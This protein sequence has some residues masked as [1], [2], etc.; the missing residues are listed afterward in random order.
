LVF[1]AVTIFPLHSPTALA[2]AVPKYLQSM[3]AKHSWTFK[4][5]ILIDDLKR[6]REQLWSEAVVR[7]R[8]SLAT[9]APPSSWM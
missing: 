4:S 8:K 1:H 6:D 2:G 9:H 3:A 5:G 7:Y